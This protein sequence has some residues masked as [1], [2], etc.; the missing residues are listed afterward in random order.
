LVTNCSRIIAEA[1]RRFE[2]YTSGKDKAAV[3]PNLRAAIFGISV[4]YGTAIEYS[5]LKK[6]WQTTTSID[7]KEICLGALASLQTPD[8]LSDYLSLL[9]HE[10]ATQDMHTG[11]IG[12]A[13]NP[14]TRHG[15][16]LYI[17][18]NFDAIRARLGENMVVM[19]LFIRH[20]LKSF[21]DRKTEKEIADFFAGRDN[22]GYDRSLAVVRD[23]VLGRAAYRERD[24]A[25][26]LEWL[27][28]NGHA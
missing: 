20:S 18:Q 23:T 6:E 12:L 17:Q 16:W 27:K 21:A 28:A 14:K 25:A 11:A 8:L 3:H 9:F 1:Q 10:V 19:D 4:R 24:G 13:T 22:S 15:F 5:A 26:I 2:L 7:G